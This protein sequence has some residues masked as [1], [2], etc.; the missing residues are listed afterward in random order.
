MLPESNAYSYSGLPL[1]KTLLCSLEGKI[2]F[3]TWQSVHDPLSAPAGAV[4]ETERI[5]KHKKK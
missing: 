1:A 4:V 5:E 3:L 2:L